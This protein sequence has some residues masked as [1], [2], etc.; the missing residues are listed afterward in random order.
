MGDIRQTYLAWKYSRMRKSDPVSPIA[1]QESCRNLSQQIA[2]ALLIAQRYGGID[3]AH[4][5]QWVIDQM[6][7]S[8]T[9]EMYPYWVRM[10]KSGADGPDTY[11]WDEG[12]AP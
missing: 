8:L 11:S 6:V 12:I 3:G 7:R 5:K 2:A 10:K 4:H 9:A 1:W